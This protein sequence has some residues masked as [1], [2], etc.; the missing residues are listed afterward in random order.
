MELNLSKLNR[1]SRLIR[2]RDKGICFMCG[3]TLNIFKME[4]HHIYPK[5][6]PKYTEKAYNLDNGIKLCWNC[7]RKVVHS[8]WTNWKKFTVMFK[9]YIKRKGVREFNTRKKKKLK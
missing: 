8:S 1:W 5:G 3:E 2:L 6:D 9:Q 4:A 7:H